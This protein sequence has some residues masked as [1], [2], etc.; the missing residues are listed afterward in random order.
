MIKLNIQLF[1]GASSVEIHAEDAK[2]LIE[3][4]HFFSTIPHQC[5]ICDS[6]LGFFYRDI[7]GD[8]YWGVTCTGNVKHSLNF[9]VFKDKAKGLYVKD[10]WTYFDG[11]EYVKI[12]P[13]GQ[14]KPA[15]APQQAQAKPKDA[16]PMDN[17]NKSTAEDVDAFWKAIR[18]LDVKPPQVWALFDGK[19]QSLITFT[20]A[21]LKSL[22]QKVRDSVNPPV[23]KSK[24]MGEGRID[25]G[26]S[27]DN[28][29]GGR[30]SATNG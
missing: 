23:A 7:E 12:K 1:H 29:G 11:Q 18:A 20:P 27:F 17:G 25:Q 6:P 3:N 14:S 8:E 19:I 9:G 15:P 5:A 13:S 21:Q 4:A 28:L 24:G 16:E 26:V 22:E 30:R 2:G 10:E